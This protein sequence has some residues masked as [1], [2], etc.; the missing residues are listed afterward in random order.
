MNREIGIIASD[1][2]L[3]ERI[4]EMFRKEVEEGR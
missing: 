4:V 2:E 1:L 3:K